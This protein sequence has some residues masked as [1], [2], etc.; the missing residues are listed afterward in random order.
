MGLERRDADAEALLQHLHR[1][2][3]TVPRLVIREVLR[4]LSDRHLDKQFIQ[5]SSH[6]QIVDAPIPSELVTE[7]TRRGLP[8]KADAFI[9]AFAEWQTVDFLI[10]DNRHFL[11]L[12]TDAFSVRT[13][14]NSWLVSKP[15]ARDLPAR[16]AGVRLP[17][18]T[19][20]S[21]SAVPLA[22]PLPS[23]RRIGLHPAQWRTDS[24]L[25]WSQCYRL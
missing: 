23:S 20:L 11:N 14:E 17:S 19:G 4:N 1:L 9:G 25:L 24:G 3:V 21:Y 22:Q 5:V 8:S 13:P 12:S 15:G 6:F 18:R 7:Y 2:D 10:S 16:P